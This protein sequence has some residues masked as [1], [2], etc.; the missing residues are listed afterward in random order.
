MPLPRIKFHVTDRIISD[1]E[2]HLWALGAQLK[3][4]LKFTVDLPP[5]IS[6]PVFK[7]DNSVLEISVSDSQKP[8]SPGDIAYISGNGLVSRRLLDLSDGA[9]SFSMDT[10]R[11]EGSILPGPRPIRC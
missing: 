7:S 1:E 6:I 3:P 4:S 11:E 9:L 8:P 2:S 5:G 10:N